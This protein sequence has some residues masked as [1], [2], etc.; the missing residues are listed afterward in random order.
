MA[1]SDMQAQSQSLVF[2]WDGNGLGADG[3]LWGGEALLGRPG[4]WRQVASMRR[5]R[6]P[7]GERAQR[8][9]WRSAWS[10]C[11]DA[12][13]GWAQG[14]AVPPLIHQAWQRNINSPQ[15]SAVGRL[16]DAAASLTGVLHNAT[17]DGQGPMWLEAL[18]EGQQAEAIAL[19]LVNDNEGVWRTDWSPLVPVLIDDTLD[20]ARR[21]AIFHESLAR[22]LLDQALLVRR[23]TGI[24]HVGLCGGVFQNRILTERAVALLEQQGFSVCLPERLPVNDGALALGQIIEFAAQRIHND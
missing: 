17:Y 22:A 20:A 11:W 23:D 14:P 1:E 3:S 4:H 24:N 6:L 13:V 21:A 16:F 18:A 15:T 5:V 19:P 9:L 7:G 12:G 2:T 10:M 8:E